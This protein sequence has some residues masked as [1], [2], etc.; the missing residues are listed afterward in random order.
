MNFIKKITLGFCLISTTVA[1][2][3]TT[4]NEDSIVSSSFLLKP[5]PYGISVDSIVTFGKT[6]IGQPYKY[7]GT[8]PTRFD[9]S[10]FTSYLLKQFGFNLPHSATAQYKATMYIP[11]DSI[12]KG[13][14]VYFQGHRRNGSIGH[15]GIVVSDSLKNGAFDFLHAST[16]SGIIISHSR[17]P[18]YNNRLVGASRV[19]NNTNFSL[20][21]ITA[22]TPLA[23]EP[24]AEA[25]PE[26]QT[27]I[28]HSVQKGDTLYSL[29]RRYNI[30][31]DTLK[32]L[33]H[34]SSNNIRIGQDLTITR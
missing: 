28:I 34:L 8:G 6:F 30:S 11:I 1:L 17:E 9:C 3:A 16:S 2:K 32:A 31:V 22:P 5:L 23:L 33:N 26:P 19:F 4:I 12:R 14:L 10:G 21:A 29:A 20:S 25:V 13:D 7:G 27:P 15:V 24:T 18:Y